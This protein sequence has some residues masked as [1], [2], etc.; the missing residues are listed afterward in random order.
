MQG[1]VLRWLQGAQGTALTGTEKAE[2]QAAVAD[3]LPPRC[4]KV[5]QSQR[6]MRSRSLPSGDVPGLGRR[7]KRATDKT[8]KQIDS[9]L[10]NK[11]R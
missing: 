3:S 7:A 6:W 11:K 1:G 4:G 2:G 5:G 9:E 8:L 10:T